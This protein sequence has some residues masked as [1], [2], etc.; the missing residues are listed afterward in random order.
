[1][2][3]SVEVH[4]II[5]LTIY[6][7]FLLLQV[8]VLVRLLSIEQIIK[9]ANSMCISFS[10]K[11][12]QTFPKSWLSLPNMSRTISNMYTYPFNPQLLIKTQ[13]ESHDKKSKDQRNIY[14]IYT[15]PVVF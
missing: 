5:K 12:P 13:V 11:N 4:K 1:M 8:K 14:N 9:D 6:N 15:W 2:E 3:V 7:T 10:V